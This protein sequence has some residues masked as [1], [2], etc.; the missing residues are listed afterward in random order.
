M[1]VKRDLA[2]LALADNAEIFKAR[3]ISLKYDKEYQWKQ[4]RLI[5]AADRMVCELLDIPVEQIATLRMYG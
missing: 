1:L 4:L 5:N 3:Y 2:R